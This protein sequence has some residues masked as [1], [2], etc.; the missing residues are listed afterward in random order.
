MVKGRL[1]HNVWGMCNLFYNEFVSTTVAS[2]FELFL[3]SFQDSFGSTTQLGVDERLGE[4]EVADMREM[5]K[6]RLIG[7]LGGN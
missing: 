5:R 6:L 7:F 1:G 3:I 4:E 2:V